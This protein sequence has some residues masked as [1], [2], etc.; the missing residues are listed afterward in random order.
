MGQN[1]DGG[2]KVGVEW[3]PDA[4]KVFNE[5]KVEGRC[6]ICLHVGSIHPYLHECYPCTQDS[7][8]RKSFGWKGY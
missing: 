4:G 2:V 1:N 3:G 6:K 8:R 7:K 5:L